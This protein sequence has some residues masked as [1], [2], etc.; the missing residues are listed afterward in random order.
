MIP[1]YQNTPPWKSANMDETPRDPPHGP[2]T[3]NPTRTQPYYTLRLRLR[4]QT[5]LRPH[6]SPLPSQSPQSPHRC[7]KI[8]YNVTLDNR[9][10]PRHRHQQICWSQF[11]T[12]FDSRFSIWVDSIGVSI[13]LDSIVVSIWLDPLVFTIWFD[14]RLTYLFSTWVTQFKSHFSQAS[15]SPTL[16]RVSSKY[17]NTKIVEYSTILII[18]IGFG[19]NTLSEKN[20][21]PEQ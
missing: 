9:R 19:E 16:V 10:Y 2:V 7:I 12:W 18:E 21:N 17:S 20:K 14:S 6:A 3:W 11:S 1:D 8:P 15:G 4:L 5:L 13:W